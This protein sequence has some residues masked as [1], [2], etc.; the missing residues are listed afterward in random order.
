MAHKKT[1][2][3][4]VASKAAKVLRQS[5]SSKKAKSSA[6]RAL[7]QTPRHRVIQPAKRRGSVPKATLSKVIRDVSA[8]RKAA[9]KR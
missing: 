1:T 4:K 5:K 8:S 7:A 2:T 3:K 6:A 9:A